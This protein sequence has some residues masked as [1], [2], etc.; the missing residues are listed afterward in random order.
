MDKKKLHIDISVDVKEKLDKIA[1]DRGIK[2]NELIRFILSEYLLKG[3][4]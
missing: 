1:K 3:V 4:R 2:T